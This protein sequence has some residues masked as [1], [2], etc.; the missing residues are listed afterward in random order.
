MTAEPGKTP[1]FDALNEKH[2]AVVRGLLAG[3]DYDAAGSQAGYKGAHVKSTVY[4]LTQRDDV[5]AALAEASEERAAV[6]F[7]SGDS[8]EKSLASGLEVANHAIKNGKNTAEKMKGVEL[9]VKIHAQLPKTTPVFEYRPLSKEDEER[10]A[11]LCVKRNPKLF[12]RLLRE[13]SGATNP[14]RTAAE[15]VGAGAE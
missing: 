2:R 15:T 11:R 8:I 6:I 10:M 12:E 5:K 1:A 9:L 14:E 13:A 7:S 4:K 3:L